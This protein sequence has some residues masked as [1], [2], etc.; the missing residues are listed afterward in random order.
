MLPELKY[1][2]YDSYP[3][4]SVRDCLPVTKNSQTIL[5]FSFMV[6]SV[7]DEEKRLDDFPAIVSYDGS[8]SWLAPIIYTSTCMLDVTYFPWDQQV[9]AALTV[10]LLLQCALPYDA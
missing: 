1:P 8:V 5:F 10:N 2:L 6:Y 7:S 4:E 3:T 9:I